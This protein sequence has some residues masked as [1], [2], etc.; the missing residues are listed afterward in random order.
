MN[1]HPFQPH[2]VGWMDEW[3]DGWCGQEALFLAQQQNN[4]NNI[5]S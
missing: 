1:P 2:H 5:F 3:M 4:N